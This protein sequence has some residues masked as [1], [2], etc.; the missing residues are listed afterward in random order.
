VVVFACSFLH[1]RFCDTVFSIFIFLL[2]FFALS[3][4][5]YAFCGLAGY[6]Y[7]RKPREYPH[8]W[9]FPILLPELGARGRLLRW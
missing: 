8:R 2:L 9:P 5:T 6:Q 4:L 7:R 1:R 3:F